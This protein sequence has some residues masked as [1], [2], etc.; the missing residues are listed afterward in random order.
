RQYAQTPEGQFQRYFQSPEMD[1]YFGA[2]SRGTGAPKDLAAMTALASQKQAP[3]ATPADLA[4]YYR[5][6]SAAGRGNMDEVVSALTYGKSG[7]EAENLTAW[8]KANPML[9]FREYNRRFPSG[10]P[11]IGPTP[12]ALQAGAEET[13]GGELLKQQKYDLSDS[14]ISQ[15]SAPTQYTL[16]STL[17]TP[18]SFNTTAQTFLQNRVLDMDPEGK[19]LQAAFTNPVNWKPG[20]QNLNLPFKSLF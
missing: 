11:T 5:S 16:P 15:P 10:E 13:R 19:S 20:S 1:Q 4:T 2:A 12:A 9:A 6:Q 17:E 14:S 3:G 18:G 8:A 7:K